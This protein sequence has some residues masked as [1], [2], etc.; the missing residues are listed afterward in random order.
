MSSPPALTIAEQPVV[1][2]DYDDLALT[3]FGLELENDMSSLTTKISTFN[4]NGLADKAEP[5][6]LGMLVFLWIFGLISTWCMFRQ[7]R[8]EN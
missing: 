3:P 4:M 5:A 2:D 1:H 7:L 6:I 8:I